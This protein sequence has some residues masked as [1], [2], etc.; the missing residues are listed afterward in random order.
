MKESIAALKTKDGVMPTFITHPETNGPHPV[1]IF[2]MDA[3]GYREELCD[4]ARR[5]ATVGYYCMLP[6]LYYRNGGPSFS[7]DKG[8]WEEESKKMFAMMATLTNAKIVADTQAL[9]DHAA[10][11][12]AAA[13]GPKGCI[14]YCM[15]GQFVVS[16]AGAYPQDF[17]ATVSLHG[18]KILTPH[19]DSPHLLF[20]KLQGEQYFGFAEDDPYVPL[21]EVETITQ[22][23]K[24]NGAQALVEV[25]PGT[26][27]GF[28]FPA[29]P[30][31]NKAEAERSWEVIFP[32]LRRQLG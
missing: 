26:E 11:D 17:R 21:D 13:E 15:S 4:I 19:D 5:C 22:A 30:A 10:N 31:Y 18:V 7:R 12:P 2:Y 28:V 24:E 14:G 29:R 6:N 20:S 3:P 27:H 1:V 25:H 32:L 9:L 23:L 8:N 16:I